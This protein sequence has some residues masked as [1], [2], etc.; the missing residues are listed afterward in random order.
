[1][2]IYKTLIIIIIGNNALP[3]C[4]EVQPCH[5][6]KFS[7]PHELVLFTA[8]HEL[9][10]V[11]AIPILKVCLSRIPTLDRGTALRDHCSQTVPFTGI[12]TFFYL[13]PIFLGVQS[14]SVGTGEN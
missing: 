3:L 1:M 10:I 6:P 14:I 7:C 4:L 9:G 12:M 8:W 13:G 5:H 2:C 11:Q